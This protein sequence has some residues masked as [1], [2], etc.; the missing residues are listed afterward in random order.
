M[1]DNYSKNSKQ[2]DCLSQ[3]C[4]LKEHKNSK[5]HL[6]LSL[7]LIW[8]SITAHKPQISL[9]MLCTLSYIMILDRI[10]GRTCLIFQT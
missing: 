8:D 7:G 9:Y 6:Q 10:D 4:L 3:I 2:S 1:S 5:Q